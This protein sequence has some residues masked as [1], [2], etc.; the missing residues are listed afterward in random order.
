MAVLHARRIVK[1]GDTL[2]GKSRIDSRLRLDYRH[3]SADA[4]SRR[5]PSRTLPARR[6]LVAVETGQPSEGRNS[7]TAL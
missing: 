5:S 3:P 1:S 6:H 2:T 7:G 4:G